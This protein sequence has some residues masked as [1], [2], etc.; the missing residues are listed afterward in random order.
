M[1]W[2]SG[3]FYYIHFAIY[4]TLTALLVTFLIWKFKDKSYDQKLRPIR[5]LLFFLIAL[6]VV[7]VFWLIAFH[8]VLHPL[9][10]PIVFCSIILYAY[11]LFAFKNNRFSDAAKSLSVFPS[12]IAGLAFLIL[13]SSISPEQLAGHPASLVYALASH[14]FLFH[15]LM[16]GIAIY[17]LATGIYTVRKNNYFAA[18]LAMSTYIAIATAISLYIGNDISIFGP[19][20][21]FLGFL[22]DAVGYVPGQ[23]V[24][25]AF[26][27]L[28]FFTAHKL[29]GRKD[30]VSQ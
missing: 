5:Y 20:S 6:E 9:R 16:I 23:L 3:A 7:K 25:I 17:I 12:I 14:S 22:Y 18:F 21:G 27:F 19:N 11:P 15:F 30:E 2:E 29:A 28:V 8:G 1:F 24:I 10:F 26:A 4:G 13:P